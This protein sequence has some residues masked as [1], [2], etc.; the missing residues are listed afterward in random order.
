MWTALGLAPL[1]LPKETSFP[2]NCR[3]KQLGEFASILNC[4]V[5]TR[6]EW[7]MGMRLAY[8]VSIPIQNELGMR[9]QLIH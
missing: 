2:P 5:G 6:T 8:S 1:V 4:E 3:E 7:E 9:L